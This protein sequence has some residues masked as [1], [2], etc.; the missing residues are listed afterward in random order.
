MFGGPGTVF[1]GSPIN[2]A[3]TFNI[4]QAM[5][6]S[7]GSAMLVNGLMQSIL[8]SIFG[9]NVQF[10][11][12]MPQTNLYDQFRQRAA[13]DMQQQVMAKGAS[14]DQKT[15]EQMFRGFA[16]LAGTPFGARERMAAQT[17]AGDLAML[18]PMLTQ[19]APD[20]VDRMHGS[21]GSAAVMAQR[22]AY[23]SRYMTD[24]VSGMP[25]MQAESVKAITDKVFN[26]LFAE[27]RD[28]GEMRGV[29][30]G[31]AGAM[32]DEMSRRGILGSAPRSL[33]QIAQDQ[34]NRRMGPVAPGE[35]DKTMKDLVDAPD[36]NDRVQQFEANR[37]TDKI[38]AMSGAVAAMKD[39]FGENGR[40][41]APMSELF[42]ALQA[43][44]QNNLSSMNPAD[45][46]RMV[47]NA[48]NVARMTGMSLDTMMA[49]IGMAGQAGDRYGLNRAFATGIATNSAAFAQAYSSNFGGVTGFNLM[50]KEKAMAFS[51]EAQAAGLNSPFANSYAAL[52]R[53]SESGMIDPNKHKEVA[54]YIAQVKAGTAKHKNPEEI[55]AML[56]RNG[57]R[58]SDFFT[59]QAQT[60]ANQA[61]IFGTPGIGKM[62]A[63][64]QAAEVREMLSAS[65][66][67]VLGTDLNLNDRQISE[68]TNIVSKSLIGM[69]GDEAGKY[70]T[71][72]YTFLVKK[73]K[74]KF[75][76]LDENKIR[77]ALSKGAG[78]FGE[79]TEGKSNDVL[80]FVNTQNR[81][82]TARNLAA[83]ESESAQQRAYAKFNRGSPLQRIFDVIQ[84]A[85]D[86]TT[87]KGAM[88][89]AFGAYNDVDLELA[90]NAGIAGNL[91][92]AKQLRGR[93]TL[94]D[95]ERIRKYLKPEPG[96][97]VDEAGIRLISNAYGIPM[98]ELKAL[99]DADGNVSVEDIA[100]KLETAKIKRITTLGQESAN[101]LKGLG[102]DQV[103]T[104]FDRSTIGSMTAAAMHG[105]NKQASSLAMSLAEALQNDTG[106]LSMLD[107]EKADYLIGGLTDVGRF[108]E[109]LEAG[110]SAAG[111]AAAGAVAGVHGI[112]NRMTALDKE[113]D[114]VEKDLMGLAK[115][116]GIEYKDLLK[117]VGASAEDMAELDR[118]GLTKELRDARAEVAA[119]KTPEEK[120]AANKKLADVKAKISRVAQSRG[121]A[122]ESVMGK[123]DSKLTAAEQTKA[124]ALLTKQTGLDKESLSL[125]GSAEKLADASGGKFTMKDVL[126]G[127]ADVGTEMN[128]DVMRNLGMTLGEDTRYGMKVRTPEEE[129]AD[130]ERQKRFEAIVA[131]PGSELNKLLKQLNPDRVLSETD[132]E[133]IKKAGPG[134][135]ATVA[136]TASA[137]DSL[138]K[139]G[140]KQ[141][142]IQEMFE[143]KNLE[144]KSE[145]T[146]TLVKS[147]DSNIMNLTKTGFM[148]IDKLIKE[149]DKKA[150]SST[151]ARPQVV[152]FADGTQFSGTMELTTGATVLTA[153]S[154]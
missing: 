69:T 153:Q 84:N 118:L 104:D 145:E 2:P 81:A 38:K 138:A 128:M 133:K 149:Q 60:R 41:D 43:I 129:K 78:N 98:E 13:F 125:L 131:D 75:P 113:R 140:F 122:V 150:E 58:S 116:G 22:M 143:G 99:K 90:E 147:L 103:K 97:V 68:M 6:M 136:K 119:A 89:S 48:S 10:G 79:M 42:N 32:F 146:K 33:Q 130:Q 101:A 23:G 126:G 28:L 67:S 110:G 39:I 144:G 55:A 148:D 46:E 27:G 7:G 35:L 80:A 17:M 94:Q 154:P 134:T 76:N 88:L 24:P 137:L 49:N 142:Q 95:V 26:N 141:S 72:D 92:T 82:Q 96:E 62:T 132:L 100:S 34:L 21:R 5:G 77:L 151:E 123:F 54:D 108:G 37:I 18:M 112:R 57:I 31:Q 15:Y 51:R 117:H 12:F 36:F 87:L 47:R 70:S 73:I 45:V 44:T 66:S 121:F 127:A 4:A 91:E 109:K 20:L 71:G 152:R 61:T 40:S 83:A 53:M 11:Q 105:T 59:M 64:S 50:D 93:A 86:K 29:T 14:I 74:E 30:A 106:M 19:M 16:N 9:N 1:T 63:E 124:R 85:D 120:E 139:L 102:F 107:K 135:K 25:G 115:S 65:F 56:S 8:P 111:L 52:I 3:Q 114:A